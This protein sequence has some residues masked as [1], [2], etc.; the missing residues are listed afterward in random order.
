MP[1]TTSILTQQ[2]KT[3]YGTL[4]LGAY[5]SSLCLCDWLTRSNRASIDK[6]I[7][8]Y[9]KAEYKPQTCATTDSA[10]KQLNAYFAGGKSVFELPLLLLGS[11]FQQAVWQ[12]LQ[13][14][15]YGSTTSY[16]QLA[17]QINKP[18]AAR[19][20]ANANNANALSIFVPCHRVI[21]SDGALSGYAGGLAT[22]R[23]LLKLEQAARR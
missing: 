14:I 16:R 18:S 21:G 13:K 8:R 15:P 4:L 17:Q 2:H 11:D 7:Q 23:T 22:K 10:I 6:R 20:V 5:E 3:P 19:A 9:L 1:E 12:R